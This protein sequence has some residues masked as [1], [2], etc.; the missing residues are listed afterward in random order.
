MALN[1]ETVGAVK[2][3]TLE[4]RLATEIA[5]DLKGE[6]ETYVAETPGPTLLDMSGVKYISSYLVG[7]LVALRTRLSERGFNLEFAGLDSK[8]RFVLKVSGLDE[9]F[10]YHETRA[11]GIAALA[12]SPAA[13]TA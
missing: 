5:Q 12:A 10:R 4:G 8:H 6:F 2:V 3:V 11:E 1:V 9:L 7:V 13:K